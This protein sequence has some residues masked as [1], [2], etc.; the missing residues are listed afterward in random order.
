MRMLIVIMGLKNTIQPR[1][2]LY[3]GYLFTFFIT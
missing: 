2:E 3:R 1:K